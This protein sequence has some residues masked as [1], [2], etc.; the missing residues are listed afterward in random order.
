M[1]IINQDWQGWPEYAHTLKEILEALG[2]HIEG[3]KVTGFISE[4]TLD[5]YVALLQDDGMGY[6][7][8]K[9]YI[10]TVDI[11]HPYNDENLN[12][13][14]VNIF[15]C[16]YDENKVSEI[17]TSTLD[18]MFPDPKQ[19]PSDIIIKD[20]LRTSLYD[21]NPRFIEKIVD[22]KIK[23]AT[24]NTITIDDLDDEDPISG[25]VSL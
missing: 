21:I 6:G 13:P 10:T 16:E 19:Y 23:Q 8:N 22:E 25:L 20:K 9:E 17:V 14:I 5:S 3:D 11:S 2:L 15:R 1:K 12:A 7:I 18:Y 24:N 4:K